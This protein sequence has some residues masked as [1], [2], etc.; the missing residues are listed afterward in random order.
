MDCNSTVLLRLHSRQRLSP[1]QMLTGCQPGGARPGRMMLRRSALLHASLQ[2]LFGRCSDGSAMSTY[3]HKSTLDVAMR[4]AQSVQIIATTPRPFP[5][6]F[7][8]QDE[9]T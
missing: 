5:C 6:T 1:L 4:H 2:L 8:P 9:L 7:N 3:H